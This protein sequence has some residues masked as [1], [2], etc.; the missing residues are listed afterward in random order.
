MNNDNILQ[1]RPAETSTI[2]AAA[3]AGLG[4]KAFDWDADTVSYVTV[5]I[6]FVPAAVT[7]LVMTLRN[8]Q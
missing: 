3:L 4:A 1:R 5:L 6:G 7:W 2:V 8:R